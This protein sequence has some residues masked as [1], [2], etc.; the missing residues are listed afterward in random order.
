MSQAGTGSGRPH[1]T[2]RV[3][4]CLHFVAVVL[5]DQLIVQAVQL[6][7]QAYY[8]VWLHDG[9]HVG[10][11]HNVGE[12]DGHALKRLGIL[13]PTLEG[14]NHVLWLGMSRGEGAGWAGRYQS[15]GRLD[16]VI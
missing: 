4:D 11:A 10:V 1:H 16:Q 2:H 6:V 13:L 5:V 3:A 12:H 7:E 9:R 8:V 15:E 14:L